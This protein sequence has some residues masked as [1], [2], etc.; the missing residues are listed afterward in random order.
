MHRGTNSN[1]GGACSSSSW[2]GPV[3]CQDPCGLPSSLSVAAGTRSARSCWSIRGRCRDM[4]ACWKLLQGNTRCPLG[5]VSSWYVSVP[6]GSESSTV[7]GPQ[8]CIL[9]LVRSNTTRAL[10]MDRRPNN[11]GKSEFGTVGASKIPDVYVP[12]SCL[13]ITSSW[14]SWVQPWLPWPTPITLSG[15]ARWVS[16]GRRPAAMAAFAQSLA[17]RSPPR[18]PTDPGS[19]SNDGRPSVR[20]VS[21]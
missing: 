5:A 4:D 15:L 20:R 16:V 6:E 1:P 8:R 7:P 21:T 17:Q 13:S 19:I 14:Q 9:L 10:C 2:A 18:F 12:L 3:V 11:P